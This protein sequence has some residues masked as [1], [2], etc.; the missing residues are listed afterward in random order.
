MVQGMNSTPEALKDIDRFRPGKNGME[1][2]NNGP[3]ILWEEAWSRLGREHLAPDYHT[4]TRMEKWALAYMSH[5][6]HNPFMNAESLAAQAWTF[7]IEMERA[8][9]V[10]F[11]APG[12]KA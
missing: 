6:N 4:R 8:R 10:A 12:E 2:D 1:S 11:S 3:Y 5:A 7:A 9:D